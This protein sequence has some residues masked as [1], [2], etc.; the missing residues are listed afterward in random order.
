MKKTVAAMAMQV[1]LFVGVAPRAMANAPGE[2]TRPRD[3]RPA[4][5]KIWASM[6]RELGYRCPG[7]I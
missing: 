1:F 6:T 3:R 2:R 4:K 5:A 7:F